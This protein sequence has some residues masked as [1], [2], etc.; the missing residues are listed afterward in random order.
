MRNIV[1]VLLVADMYMVR[2]TS[3][4]KQPSGMKFIIAISTHVKCRVYHYNV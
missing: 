2:Q 1:D 4:V 3:S